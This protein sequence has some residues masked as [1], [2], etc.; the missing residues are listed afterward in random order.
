M[1]SQNYILWLPSWYPNELEPYNGD[2]IQR[3]A[4]VAALNNNIT[5]IFFTQYGEGKASGYKVFKNVTGTLTEIIVHIPF[6]PSGFP[7]ADRLRYN[8]TFYNFSKRFLEKYFKDN[9]L[10][11]LV[12]VHV[13]MKAGN[14]ALWIKKKFGISYI[15]SEQASTYL[16]QAPD[17]F[18]NRHWIYRLQVK[19]I[20]SEAA[21]VT[22]VSLAI[23]KLLKQ[24]FPIKSFRVIHN[25][26]DTRFFYPGSVRNN[27]FTY[28]HVS[29]LT[30]QK[31]IFGILRVFKNLA[32]IA[33]DWKLLLVGPVTKEIVNFIEIEQLNHLIEFVGE[34]PYSEVANYMRQAHVKVLFS[35]HE[36]FPC[37]VVEALCCGLPVVSS[38][39]AGVN[40]AVNE[41]NGIL[42]ESQNEDALLKAVIKIRQTYNTFDSAGI[43]ADAAK[44]FSYPVIAKQFD[45]LYDPLLSAG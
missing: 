5:V 24:L 8:F 22:N 41:L 34:V 9:G 15:L 39:V 14:F 16:I 32:A 13:P 21:I 12:H 25:V 18:F 23:G 44:K 31:N 4:N 28:I 2:F 7:F 6:K 42:V 40:E 43:A 1:N 29:S 11:N 37:V 38:D 45:E 30:D 35:K 33:D 10:P 36:N 17:N 27:I 19:K 3:H 20:F 26:V